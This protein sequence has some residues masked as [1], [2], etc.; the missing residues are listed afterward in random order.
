VRRKSPIKAEGWRGEQE[1]ILRCARLRQ[2][3]GNTDRILE[4]SRGDLNWS[5]VVAATLQHNLAPVVY[6][7]LGAV[8]GAPLPA[9]H[10]NML[11]EA[12]RDSS[13]WSM[14]LL[15]EMFRLQERFESEEI[16]ALPYKGPVLAWIAYGDFTRRACT[17][18]DFVVP[19]QYI[20]EAAMVLERAGYAAAFDPRELHAGEQPHAPGEYA[21]LR[22]INFIRV[23]L[24]TERTLRY[25][26]VALD[27]DKM[28]RRLLGVQLAGRTLRTFSVEDTLVML[29][30]HGAK[31]FWDRLGWMLDIA[32]MISS[33]P[34]DWPAALQIAADLNSTRVFLLGL[35]LAHDLLDAPLPESVLEQVRQDSKVRWLAGRVCDPMAGRAKP[36]AGVIR[37]TIFRLKSQDE[38]A[39]GLLHMARL[40]LSPTESDRGAVGLPA[41]F[42]FLYFLVRPWRLLRQYGLGLRSPQGE[43]DLG[44]FDATSP[45]VAERMLSLAETG[46]GDVVYDLGSGDGSIV[47]TAAEKYGIPSVGIDIHP[48]RIAEA[49]AKAKKHGVEARAKFLLQD[50]K[51]ADISEATVVTLYTSAAGNLKLVDRLREQLR[52]GARIVSRNFQIFGWPADKSV[53]HV[54]PNGASTYL[55]LWKVKEPGENGSAREETAAAM[56]HSALEKG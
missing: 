24:H 8:M 15:Q 37:R 7:R 45:E 34:V 48:Q 36:S 47:V 33:Q 5:E 18:L 11:R 52:P 2:D 13:R 25:F 40:A 54:M 16:P 30:V 19:Q 44:I 53:K 55:Y 46:P 1:L 4:L 14:V 20:P 26:P 39:R 56:Q 28:G 27:F 49:R 29:C 9:E 51:T 38:F 6:E 41:R 35:S 23:E 42:S 17:D 12:V 3:A 22:G 50:A 43:P 10:R 32:G 21:F 31:H